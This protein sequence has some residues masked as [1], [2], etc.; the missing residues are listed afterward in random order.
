M[1]ELCSGFIIFGNTSGW[2]G[3][4]FY[5]IKDDSNCNIRSDNYVPWRCNRMVHIICVILMNSKISKLRVC[6][7]MSKGLMIY[8]VNKI[9]QTYPENSI[10]LFNRST[11]FAHNEYFIKLL[12][13]KC[14]SFKLVYWYTDI[15]FTVEKYP[16]YR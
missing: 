9:K 2:F 15:V 7:L 6:K 12:K 3:K 16:Q 4:L 1:S 11:A 10:C 5:D 8:F 14:S 13:K